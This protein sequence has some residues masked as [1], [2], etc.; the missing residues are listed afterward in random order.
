MLIAYLNIDEV[1]HIIRTADDPKAKLMSSFAL[2]EIQADYILDLKLRH[3]QKIEEMKIKGEQDELDAERRG[4]EALL[5]DDDKMRK[6]IGDELKEDAKKYGDDRRCP[7][8]ARP[9]AA[10]AGSHRHHA[11]RTGHRRAVEGRLDPRRQGFDLDPVALSYKSGDEY[12]CHAQGKTNQLLILLDDKGR[13]YTLNPRELPSARSQ[14]EPVTTRLD[15]QDG[16]AHRHAADGRSVRSLR[17][18]RQRRLWLCRPSSAISNRGSRPARRSSIWVARLPRCRRSRTLDPAQDRYAVAT[19]EGRLLLFPL[20]E[21]PELAKGKGN[22]LVTLKGEDRILAAAV[23]PAGAGLELV[24][25]KRTLSLKLSDLEHYAG[26]RA[27]RGGYLPRGFQRVDSMNPLP[28]RGS[29][30]C[31]LLETRCA[32]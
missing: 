1:I 22:K 32:R 30:N 19:A 16:G 21:L 31:G 4:L 11:G 7:I 6:L 25:G 18:R 26:A 8:N 12:L 17:R 27:S 28:G 15:L 24:C 20:A 10:G 9:P 3:L 29:Y 5:G 2:S 14:G 13:S 23:L